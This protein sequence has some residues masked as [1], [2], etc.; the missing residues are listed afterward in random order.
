M[1]LPAEAKEEKDKL[2][3]EA[4][5]CEIGTL[6]FWGF[7]FQV[8]VGVQSLGLRG[9]GLSGFWVS[10]VRLIRVLQ[11]EDIEITSLSGYGLLSILGLPTYH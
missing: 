7:Q 3:A 4:G 9:L 10:G 1:P 6:G 5:R 11:I 2:S 8:E